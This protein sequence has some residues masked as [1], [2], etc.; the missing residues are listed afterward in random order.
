MR[1]RF[2]NKKNMVGLL[3]KL[4]GFIVI[5]FAISSGSYAE[6]AKP[7]EKNKAQQEAEFAEKGKFQ[8]QS[9]PDAE[10]ILRPLWEL[11][12]GGGAMQIPDYRGAADRRGYV[13]PFVYPVYRG[14]FLRVDNEGVRGILYESRRLELD[15]SADGAIPVSSEKIEVR[16][17]MPDLDPIIQFGPSLLYGIWE[18]RQAAR[19]LVLNLPVRG[20]FAIDS[21]VDQIGY[22]FSPHA[23]FYQNFYLVD[24]T[25]RLGLS[26]GLEF[27]SDEYHDYLYGVDE[28]FMTATRPAFDADGGY[29]GTRFIATMQGRTRK[30][31]VSFFARYDRVDNAV[32]ADSPLVVKNGGLTAGFVITWFIAQS[33]KMVEVTELRKR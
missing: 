18:D 6:E 33:K 16:D 30:T 22:T 21:G 13:F 8:E 5:V 10:V 7:M 19:S 14:N 26:A 11:A 17:G 24:R 2:D 27:G 29:A 9:N 23:T 1:F 15:F 31:W 32:F 12:I 25:W 20:V 3:C 28:T 4:S